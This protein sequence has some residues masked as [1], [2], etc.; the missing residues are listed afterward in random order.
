MEM[1][2]GKIGEV[3][4]GCKSQGFIQMAA[5]VF[6]YLEDTVSIVVLS[7]LFHSFSSTKRLTTDDGVILADLAN[8]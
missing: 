7:G 3:G 1:K 4:Q 5:D 8:F 2:R 6:D